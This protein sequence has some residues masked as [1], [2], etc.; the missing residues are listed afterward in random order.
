MNARNIFTTTYKRQ[1]NYHKSAPQTFA[2]GIATVTTIGK[3]SA[4]KKIAELT[5]KGFPI[6]HTFNGC[7]EIV[8]F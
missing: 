5:A 3:E 4:Q 2:R 7:G 6:I 1:H 8:K